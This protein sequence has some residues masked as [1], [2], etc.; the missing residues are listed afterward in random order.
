[1]RHTGTLFLSRT[2][3]QASTALCGAF[4]LQMLLLDRLG[5]QHTEPWRA[6]WT[7]VAAQRFWREHH[8]ALLPGAALVVELE[9]ARIH[10]LACRP[11]RSEVHARVLHCALV[12]PRSREDASRKAV[13]TQP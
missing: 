8:A 5:L 4:Q 7:G 3:P 1:M 9:R 12:P 2:P 13:S 6:T 10:T 11:P